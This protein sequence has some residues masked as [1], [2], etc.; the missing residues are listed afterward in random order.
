MFCLSRTILIGAALAG[1]SA[2]VATD[3]DAQVNYYQFKTYQFASSPDNN[4][5]SLDSTRVESAIT[6]QLDNK[7]LTSEVNTADLTVR[8]YI[9]QQSDFQSYGTSIGF[10]YGYRNVGV[11][12]SS[13]SRYR[14]YKYGKLVVE[15]I[16]NDNNKIVWRSISQRKLTE[17]MTPKSREEFIDEQVF[18]M[19]KNYPP[20]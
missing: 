3:Y 11:A 12:Y 19:F 20:Q 9:Q 13:P 15:L 10:G 4:I 17:T 7:G 18:E 14:E 1:C 6:T 2:D 16:D 5:I 8:H